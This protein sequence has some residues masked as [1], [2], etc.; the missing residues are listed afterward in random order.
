MSIYNNY[1]LKN[2]KESYKKTS[3]NL[4]KKLLHS[5]KFVFFLGSDCYELP[6]LL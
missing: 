3:Q 4:D 6:L 1:K 5:Y 2:S